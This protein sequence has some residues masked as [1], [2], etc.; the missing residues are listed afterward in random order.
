[1][2]ITTAAM[3]ANE[4]G[5][6][7]RC[8]CGDGDGG[9][10]GGAPKGEGGRLYGVVRGGLRSSDMRPCQTRRRMAMEIVRGK[11]TKERSEPTKPRCRGCCCLPIPPL[12]LSHRAFLAQYNAS[13]EAG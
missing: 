11:R 12:T 13:L 5:K 3:S 9:R 6:P 7:H 4:R 2:R 8:D 1:M 10:A